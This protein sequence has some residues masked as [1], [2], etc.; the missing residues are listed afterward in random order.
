MGPSTVQ[1]PSTVLEAEE[2]GE[3]QLSPT[4]PQGDGPSQFEELID[5]LDTSSSSA[6]A[7]SKASAPIIA[8]EENRRPDVTGEEFD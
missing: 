8:F 1:P 3:Q 5:L 2:G 4:G 6:S 7:G